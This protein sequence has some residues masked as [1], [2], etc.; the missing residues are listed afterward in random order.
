V[1]QFIIKRLLLLIPTVIGVVTIAFL[2]MRLIP[3]DAAQFILGDYATKETLAQLREQLGLTKPMHVQYLLFL[4]RAFV[5]DFGRSLVTQRPAFDEALS[6]FPYTIQLAAAGTLI[7]MLIGVPTGI[8]AAIRR[9]TPVDFLAMTFVLAGVSMPVFWQGLLFLL[10]F[11]LYLGWTPSIGVGEEGNVFS[12]LHHLALPALTLGISIA[13][14]VA[15]LTRSTMLEVVGQD[16]I[17][18]ARA[19]GLGEH[20]VIVKHALRNASLPIVTVVGINFGVQL[21][22]AVLIETVFARPGLGNTL[23]S[24]IYQRDYPMLQATVVMFASSFI[25]VNLLVDL[26]YFMLDPRLKR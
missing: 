24:S 7:S 25:L 12:Q 10:I 3:G 13:A 9:N 11:S 6:V 5:G 14:M 16:Y 23:I 17:R 4:S 21:G 8:I 2:V 20:W 1:V 22:G 19:K 18:T 26:L 15:R